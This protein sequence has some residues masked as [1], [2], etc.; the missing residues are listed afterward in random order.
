MAN[1]KHMDFDKSTLTTAMISVF[2]DGSGGAKTLTNPSQYYG[3]DGDAW[4]DGQ[5]ENAPRQRFDRVKVF[6]EV[7][8]SVA[9][10]ELYMKVFVSPTDENEA[11]YTEDTV[12][13]VEATKVIVGELI[14]NLPVA[15]GK[16]TVRFPIDPGLKYSV[17]FMRV[18]GTG[19]A[20]K[21]KALF[22]WV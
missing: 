22:V 1:P 6:Y 15:L 19:V 5:T 2:D 4:H 14:F 10:T 7:T 9:P 12:V 16:R 13:L 18:G 3:S 11:E 8:G 20:V 21:A 17:Q